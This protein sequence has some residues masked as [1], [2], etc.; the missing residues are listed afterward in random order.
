MWGCV[1]VAEGYLWII[2]FFHWSSLC[3]RTNRSATCC[4]GFE[5]CPSVRITYEHISRPRGLITISRTPADHTPFE[6]LWEPVFVSGAICGT[7]V[8]LQTDETQLCQAQ[9]DPQQMHHCMLEGWCVYVCVWVG[10]HGNLAAPFQPDSLQF[11]P[12]EASSGFAASVHK[13]PDMELVLNLVHIREDEWQ[14]SACEI[15]LV[16]LLDGCSSACLVMREAHGR[17]SVQLGQIKAGFTGPFNF[18]D[19][20]IAWKRGQYVYVSDDKKKLIVDLSFP[21]WFHALWSCFELLNLLEGSS[22]FCACLHHK[23]FGTKWLW[24]G[25]CGIFCS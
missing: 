23:R 10:G 5:V 1:W 25:V 12:L 8:M 11:F 13:N 9:M 14:I 17:S 4:A 7:S 2:C 20:L 22:N 21:V 19:Q 16:V 15:T 6:R 3:F 18:H 24:R